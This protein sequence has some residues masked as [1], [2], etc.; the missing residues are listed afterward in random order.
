LK[1]FDEVISGMEKSITLQ[2]S[3]EERLKI[4]KAREKLNKARKEI[5]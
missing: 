3:P 5:D 4:D 2:L 1:E